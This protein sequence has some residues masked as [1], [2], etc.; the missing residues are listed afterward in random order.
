VA[1]DGKFRGFA[2]PDLQTLRAADVLEEI[3]RASRKQ[4]KDTFDSFIVRNFKYNS[5][6]FEL[7]LS[8]PSVAHKVTV[9]DLIEGGLHI[10]HALA[11]M[12][13]T[14][15]EAY[16]YRLSCANGA[17]GRECVASAKRGPARIR[18]CTTNRLDAVSQNLRAIFD[19]TARVLKGL[20]P[21]LQA[22]SKL[23]DNKLD[24]QSGVRRFVDTQLR[25]MNRLHSPR[26]VEAMMQ[27]WIADGREPSA[28]GASSVNPTLTFSRRSGSTTTGFR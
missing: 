11:G 16:I 25:Q 7:V 24:G 1:R 15:I 6:G 9:G 2:R 27:A 14:E 10:R 17:I 22:V 12:H 13:A 20:S 3:Q 19:H 5:T 21:K 26:L 28:Y 4:L 23:R 8:T 18:R